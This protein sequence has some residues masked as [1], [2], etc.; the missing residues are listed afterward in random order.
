[1]SYSEKLSQLIAK[2]E[3]AETIDF[4]TARALAAKTYEDLV[5]GWDS[6]SIDENSDIN[7]L[8]S[9]W[10]GCLRGRFHTKAHGQEV[11]LQLANDARQLQLVFDLLL[12]FQI[13]CTE[14]R[15]ET[16]TAVRKFSK[17]VSSGQLERPTAGRRSKH[18]L[19]DQWISNLVVS[20]CQR[21]MTKYRNQASSEHSA[22]DA[23]AEGFGMSYSA[24]EKVVK[25]LKQK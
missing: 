15:I 4:E 1:M 20:L 21:G 7:D 23:I 12:K 17:Q 6:R 3:A 10:R 14:N 13:Y 9:F 11:F 8:R 2:L 19:R 25:A 5:A 18:G 22:C 16:P 24:V